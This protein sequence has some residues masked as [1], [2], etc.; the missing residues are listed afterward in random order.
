M[1]IMNLKRTTLRIDTDLKHAAEMQALEEDT[2]LQAI[3]NAALQQYLDKKA[4]VQAKKIVFHTH[5]LGAPLDH[6]GRSDYYPE[7]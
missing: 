2:T 4:K 6:L 3:F 5:D 7:P 1:T